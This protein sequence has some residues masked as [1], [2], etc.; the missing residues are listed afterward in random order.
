MGEE[1]WPADS[2]GGVSPTVDR[3][4]FDWV[5][6]LPHACVV[7]SVGGCLDGQ[8]LPLGVKVTNSS[9]DISV[10]GKRWGFQQKAQNF[11]VKRRGDML[12]ELSPDMTASW[13]DHVLVH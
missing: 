12:S 6:P 3:G 1:G 13:Q 10:R 8:S 9:H 11:Q 4:I 7:W 5:T 2:K